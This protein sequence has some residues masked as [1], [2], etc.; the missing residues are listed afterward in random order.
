MIAID[1]NF[2]ISETGGTGNATIFVNATTENPFSTASTQIEVSSSVGNIKRYVTLNKKAAHGYM[3]TPVEWISNEDIESRI[4]ID[5]GYVWKNNSRA[6]LGF[7]IPGSHQ[8][9]NGQ[10]VFGEDTVWASDGNGPVDDNN[11]LRLFFSKSSS[12]IGACWDVATSRVQA[13]IGAITDVWQ[14]WEIGNN[15]IKNLSNNTNFVT[16]STYSISRTGTVG[17][18]GACQYLNTGR[19]DCVRYSYIKIYEG[20]TLVRDVIPVLDKDNIPCF[21]DKLSETFYY[22]KVND[23]PSTGLTAGNV[24]QE[25]DYLQGDGTDYIITDYIATSNTRIEVDCSGRPASTPSSTEGEGTPMGCEKWNGT[26]SSSAQGGMY[27]VFPGGGGARF[28]YGNTNYY[29]NTSQKVIERGVFKLD[30]SA[31][32]IDDFKVADVTASF[33]TQGAPFALFNSLVYNSRDSTTFPITNVFSGAYYEGRIYGVKIYENN[34]LVRDYV[35]CAGTLTRGF[36]DRISG[37]YLTSV[38]GSLITGTV[39]GDLVISV[40]YSESDI[41]INNDTPSTAISTTFNLN[42]S[43]TPTGATLT[44]SSSDTSIATVDS[45]GVITAVA[46]GTATITITAQAFQDN[47]NHIYYNATS[48]TVSVETAPPAYIYTPVEYVSNEGLLQKHWVDLDYV[49]K[50]NSKVEMGYIML[51]TNSYESWQVFGEQNEYNASGNIINDNDDIRIFL[52][53]YKAYWDVTNGRVE[54]SLSNAYNNYQMLRF[55]NNYIEDIRQKSTATGNTYSISRTKTVGLFGSPKYAN[56]AN[57]R[58]KIYYVKIWEGDNLV[59][60]IIPVLDSNNIPCFFDK[61]NAN[62][63][64]YEVDGQPSTGLTAGGAIAEYSYIDNGGVTSFDNC[65]IPINYVWK[66][67]SRAVMSFKVK[68]AYGGHLFSDEDNSNRLRLY[69][70]YYGQFQ[71]EYRGTTITASDRDWSNVQNIEIGNYYIKDTDTGTDIATGATKTDNQSSYCFLFGY[72]DKIQYYSVKIYEGDTLVC[73]LVPAMANNGYKGFWDKKREQFFFDRNNQ[74]G[75]LYVGT[76]VDDIV[77]I[78]S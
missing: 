43:T 27:I 65:Y 21:F 54:K 22:Y 50:D 42:A 35:P 6:Q 38:N 32:Y 44:Y 5:L 53:N 48:K 78:G 56:A 10:Q 72:S 76:K 69:P 13:T 74:N 49:W 1:D 8:K 71:M 28:Q 23:V 57:D 59:R 61:V 51:Y 45:N 47:T 67:N 3:Y 15:Y 19:T 30:G 31:A 16:G 11:D 70:N 36:Y 39:I 41:T 18:Y 64:Y 60:D 40:I 73:D 77:V 14:N 66:T 2:R 7:V 55:G 63:H 34:V 58:I 33:V 20:D 37:N 4:W 75:R 62:F 68:S 52:Y 12:N 25:L 9:P 29:D 24:I 46:E 26:Q 17:L